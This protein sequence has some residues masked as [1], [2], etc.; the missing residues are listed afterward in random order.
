MGL[1]CTQRAVTRP[2]C[3]VEACNSWHWLSV[4]L[5]DFQAARSLT[6]S[7]T[8][9]FSSSVVPSLTLCAVCTVRERRASFVSLGLLRQLGCWLLLLLFPLLADPSAVTRSVLRTSKT[10]TD[11][12][13]RGGEASSCYRSY[14]SMLIAVIACLPDASRS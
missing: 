8:R 9:F 12:Q 5:S 14:N 4:R 3:W 6:H 7:Q 1:Q 10:W 11:D 13:P 2:R